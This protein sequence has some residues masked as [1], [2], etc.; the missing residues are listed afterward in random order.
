MDPHAIA[1]DW[2]Q[3]FSV[4]VFSGDVD[5]TVQTFLPNGWLRDSLVFT[6]D[7]R[8]LEGHTKITAYLENTLAKANLAGFRLDERPW[9]RPERVLENDAGISAGF[10]FESP[11]T[12][13]RGYAYLLQESDDRGQWKALSVFMMLENIKGH[14]ERGPEAGVYGG[15]TLSWEEVNAERRARIERNPHVLVVGAGQTGLQIAARFKQMDIPTLVIERNAAIGDQWRKRYP[16]LSLNTTKNHHTFLYQAYPTN[17]PE[18]TPRDK[19]ANWLAQ[20]AVSQDLVVWTSSSIMAHP[21]PTYE[22]VSKTWTVVIDRDGAPVEIHPIHIVIAV[23]TLGAPRI[24]AVL[25]IEYFGGTIM[26]G[27]QYKGGQ[28]FTGKR[29]LVVGAGSTAADICQ[30]LHVHGAEA[31]TMVQRSSSCVVAQKTIAEDYYRAFPDGVPLEVSDFKF[32]AMP[33]NLQRAFAKAKEAE[34]WDKEK[35][36]HE[37]LRKGGVKLNMGRDGSGIQLLIFERFGGGW[38]DVGVADLIG[39]GKVKVKQG[40]EIARFQE[41]QVI[42]TDESSE[43]VDLVIFATGYLDPREDLKQIFGEEI[44]GSTGPL[45]GLDDEGEIRGCY[46]PTGHPGLW[47][48]AGEFTTVR[49]L[50]KQLALQIKAIELGILS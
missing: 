38:I 5:A 11:K 23:G 47:Y 32:F 29:A 6:W 45:W 15:H 42:F 7:S 41:R 10:A 36:L 43:D 2:L 16:T 39:S 28:P 4:S 35:E 24:P 26:N 8:S 19:L 20:Y 40:V 33:I 25:G 22:S 34:M 12:T 14:E 31:V 49:F 18:F 17:W 50:S 30:D 13:G 21:R 46:R 37:K 48:G 27:D 1:E 9:L 44:I 3:R